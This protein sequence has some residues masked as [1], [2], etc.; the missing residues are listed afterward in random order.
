MASMNSLH[1]IRR[2][3]PISGLGGLFLIAS[4]LFLVGCADLP[5]DHPQLTRLT[6][7]ASEAAQRAA[8]L[9]NDEY[10]RE[11]HRRTFLAEQHTAVVKDDRYS[12]GGD[13]KDALSG[14]FALVTFALDGS[15]PHVTLYFHTVQY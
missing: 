11:N 13:E 2:H 1:T 9:A 15:D 7:S 4:F 8:Q 3:P 5:R 14:V 12:W 10:E 6:I